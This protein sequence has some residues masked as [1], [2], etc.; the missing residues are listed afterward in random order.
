M[1]TLVFAAVDVAFDSLNLALSTARF[2]IAAA[3]CVHQVGQA[4][5]QAGAATRAVV[6]A[7]VDNIAAKAEC[8]AIVPTVNAAIDTLAVTVFPA[9]PLALAPVTIAGY[10]P[11]AVDD[12]VAEAA[13]P[14]PFAAMSIRE[15]K[16]AARGKVKNY[17]RLT[18]DQLIAA[19]TA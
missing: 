4:T 19:L 12:A 11:A 16:A 13:A 1:N 8:T 9:A 14:C 15:L 6:Q 10:L 2:A 18:K 7:W 17:S 5:I 3:V